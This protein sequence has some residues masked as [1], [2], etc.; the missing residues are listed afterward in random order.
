MGK[1]KELRKYCIDTSKSL[2]LISIQ[3]K[4][5]RYQNQKNVYC[6]VSTNKECALVVGAY[7]KNIVNINI[8]LNVMH[9]YCMSGIRP[10]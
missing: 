7:I 8:K 1:Y 2:L 4:S 3:Q 5:I 6:Q 10:W 9:M